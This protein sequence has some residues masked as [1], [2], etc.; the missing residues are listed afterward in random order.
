LAA[1]SSVG[2]A[3]AARFG[4]T[5]RWRAYSEAVLCEDNARRPLAPG[6]SA[7]GTG[8]YCAQGTHRQLAGGELDVLLGLVYARPH[9][10]RHAVGVCTG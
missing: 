5:G 1:C 10:L 2:G 8:T 6:M 7:G 4:G 3:D 9:D